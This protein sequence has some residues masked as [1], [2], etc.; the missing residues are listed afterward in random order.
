VSEKYEREIEEILRKTSFSSTPKGPG[1]SPGWMAGLAAEWQHLL[2]DLSPTRLLAYGLGL[3]LAGYIFRWFLPELS[4]PL[5]LLA[6]VLLFAGLV[7]SMSRRSA[8][9]PSGWR[10]RAFDV[11]S[12]SPELWESL[13]RHWQSWRR[14]RGWNDRR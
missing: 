1:R 7:L 12:Q 8:S 4:A 3:A 10:G 5:S 14:G 11:R 9:P 2:A 6:F 13:K